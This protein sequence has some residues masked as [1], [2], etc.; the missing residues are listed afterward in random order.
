[1]NLSNTWINSYQSLASNED[2]NKN[3]TAFAKDSNFDDLPDFPAQ[4]QM[5][6]SADKDAI[7]LAKAPCSNKIA[8][9]HIVT[10][11]GGFRARPT[12]KFVGLV[13]SGPSAT[14]VVF[15]ASF[16]QTEVTVNCPTPVTLNSI[17]DKANMATATIP[18]TR[19]FVLH[20]ACF[21]ILP[22]RQSHRHSLNSAR[23]ILPNF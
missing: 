3:M 5:V 11:L 19:P 1:M 20:N 9:Y 22:P 7:I 21:Q 10:N 8:L 23:K 15:D 4:I 13:G 12:N 14:P 17:S 18:P 2:A 16:I 6:F